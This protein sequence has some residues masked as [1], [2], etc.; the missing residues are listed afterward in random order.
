MQFIIV[1]MKF[2]VWFRRVGDFR[3][4]LGSLGRGTVLA[5]TDS[6]AFNLVECVFCCLIGQHGFWRTA[7]V[8]Q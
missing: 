3:D 8:R 6:N 7:G 4:R 2:G 1:F 5:M